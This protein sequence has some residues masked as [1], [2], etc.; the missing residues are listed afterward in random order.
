MSWVSSVQNTRELG[1]SLVW[2]CYES[3][4]QLCSK[5]CCMFCAACSCEPYL[6]LLEYDEVL[7]TLC[8]LW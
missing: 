4:C 3:R 7:C 6:G 2:M 5:F 1:T 8:F